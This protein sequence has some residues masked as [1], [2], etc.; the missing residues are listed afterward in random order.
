MKKYMKHVAVLAMVGLFV[1]VACEKEEVFETSDQVS[2]SENLDNEDNNQTRGKEFFP[3]YLGDCGLCFQRVLVCITPT[4]DES[5]ACYEKEGGFYFRTLN[6]TYYCEG[7][8]Y[9]Q[10]PLVTITNSTPLETQC[11]YA[12]VPIN[13]PVTLT[14]NSGCA[15][16]YLCDIDVTFTSAPWSGASGFGVCE[17][18]ASYDSNGGAPMSI[19]DR[20]WFEVCSHYVCAIS[21][22]EEVRAE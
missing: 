5:W 16:D 12:D 19:L 13:T 20:E 8:G 1:F 10:I 11:F 2:T 7:E 6:L 3:A 22:K 14:S 18:E 4:N 15:H 21:P 9:E 17:T